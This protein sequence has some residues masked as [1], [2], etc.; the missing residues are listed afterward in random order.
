MR[1][2]EAV[3]S[4]ARIIG[5]DCLVKNRIPKAYRIAELDKR[6]R[7]ERTRMEAR[8]L[9]KAKLA[10]VRCPTVLEV[11]E[12]GIAMERLEGGRPAMAEAECVAAGE[13]LALLHA[14]DIIHGDFTPANLLAEGK[15]LSVIDFG[16]G[17]ISNDVEDKAVD[18][19]TM[20]RAIE[21]G[22]GRGAFISG[23]SSSPK[24][25]AVLARVKDVEKRVRYAF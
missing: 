17:F 24:A 16:L 25:D 15:T 20:L 7:S 23:Y 4:P 14:A 22:E 12:F 19:F 2:A 21:S 13:M 9:H 1:G 6:L 18:V 10:G 3:L 5:R 8:L 11:T